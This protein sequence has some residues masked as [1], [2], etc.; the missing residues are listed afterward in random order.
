MN[1]LKEGWTGHWVILEEMED[2]HSSSIISWMVGALSWELN[3]MQW[4]SCQ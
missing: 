2:Q 4:P 1:N 3:I